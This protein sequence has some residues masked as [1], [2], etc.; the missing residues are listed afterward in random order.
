MQSIEKIVL[1]GSGNVATQLAG[2]FPE[3]G[4]QIV[5]V[6][7]PNLDHAETLAI[8]SGCAATNLLSNI[9]QDAD[10]YVIAV[11]DDAISE[12]N[13]KLRLPGKMVVHTSGSVGLSAIR[14][15]SEKSG[16][17]YPLQTFT[18]VRKVNWHDIPVILES[19]DPGTR[20]LL[21][22]L[23]GKITGSVF[24]ID[25]ENRK[26]LH[27]AAVFANNFINHLLGEAGEILGKQIPF[28]I[29][30]PLVNETV[31]KAF[32]LGTEKAQTGPAKR[33]D[34]KTIEGHMKWLQSNPE[35]EKIYR[36]L[37]ESILSKYGK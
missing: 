29:L 34:M 27:L 15:I 11:K 5:Q 19:S 4:M 26:K 13:K 2:V 17:F 18:R 30:Q 28:N 21:K 3:K 33:G 14:N 37:T 31:S 7:S 10:L 23:A 6:Y 1:I 35:A 22:D 24:E 25:S 20:I 16:V 9:R 8:R 36:L 32:D 12:I